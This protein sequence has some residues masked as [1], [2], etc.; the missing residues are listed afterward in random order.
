[1][2]QLSARQTQAEADIKLLEAQ[3]AK[4]KAAAGEKTDN[5]ELDKLR[6]ENENLKQRLSQLEGAGGE[7][8]KEAGEDEVTPW[9]VNASSNK[10]ID[11]DKLIIKFGSSKIDQA[12]LDKFES[13]TGHKPHHLLRRGI[14]FSHRE[15]N[16]ILDMYAA[17]KKFFL[18]TGR[19]VHGIFRN[20]WD[21]L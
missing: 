8:E 21:I 13:V 19:V 7:A 16:T 17:G 20:F 18:Y 12:L 11:Y 2:E 6:Q 4:L 5:S 15:L 9:D 3:L 10:G 14:F 1:M